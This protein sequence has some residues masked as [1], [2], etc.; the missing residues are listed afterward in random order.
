MKKIF[1]LACLAALVFFG[2]FTSCKKDRTTTPT[3][4]TQ[5]TTTNKDSGVNS[6]RDEAYASMVLNDSK[7]ISDG[8]AK[9]QASERPLGGTCGWWSKH[10]TTIAGTADSVLYITFP[11]LSSYC[12]SPDGNLR[13]GRIVVYWNPA[14]NYFDSGATVTMTWENYSINFIGVSGS[15]TLT[16]TGKNSLGTQNFNYNASIFLN[17]PATTP[18]GYGYSPSGT[19]HWTANRTVTTS[20]SYYAITGYGSD[21]CVDGI[22]YSDTVAKGYP[23][24]LTSL[25][26]WAGG[27]AYLEGGILNIYSSTLTFPVAVEYGNYGTCAGVCSDTA[28]VAV[29][30]SGKTYYYPILMH[31]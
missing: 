22:K 4:P 2:I 23:L 17:Y 31:Y 25:P 13:M 29:T 10:D 12:I 9:G 3:T 1:S 11:P 28:K 27:C 7:N 24:Y 6:G 19:A 26:Q 16:N 15:R 21:S 14:F 18:L 5:T 20:S 30:I 8:A